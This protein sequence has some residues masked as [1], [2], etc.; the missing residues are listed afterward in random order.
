[1]DVKFPMDNY[2]RHLNATTEAERRSAAAQFLRDV[3]ERVRSLGGRGYVE[4]GVTLDFVLLFI[5]NEATYGFVHEQDVGF[6]DEA[7]RQRVV[8]CSPFTLF[9]VLA[10]VRQAV[11]SFALQ[12]STDQIL[13]LLARF[14]AQWEKFSDAMD[15]V[16]RRLDSASRAYDDL[17]GTRRRQLQR[18]VDRVD[19][20]RRHGAPERTE[21]APVSGVA[22]ISGR[23][24]PPEMP[25]DVPGPEQQEH[26]PDPGAR[27]LPAP[28]L[29]LRRPAA[30]DGEPDAG[31][32][33]LARRLT[34]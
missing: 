31:L 12:R 20:L 1:M 8:L 14:S 25:G 33:A 4:A 22:G 10:V 13:E 24:G 28:P 6:A 19:D 21:V 30:D 5:P 9:A 23:S 27:D 18:M 7:L 29:P 11:D 16:G 34:G 15:T 17:S 2:L 32:R 26:A 3:R